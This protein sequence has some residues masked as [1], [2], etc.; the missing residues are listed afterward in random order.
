MRI[1]LTGGTGVLGRATVPKLVAAGH[2][3]H[4]VSRREESDRALRGVGAEPLRLDLFDGDAVIAAAANMEAIV[5]LATHIPP[6]SQAALMKSWEL[7]NRLRRDASRNLAEAAIAAGARFVQESFAPTY[8]ANGA[9]WI[10]EEHPLDPVA[11]TLTVV[12]AENNA[13]LVTQ[14]GGVGV[15]LRFGLFYT[16]DSDQTRQMIAAARKGRL[17]LPGPPERY[18]ALIYVPDAAAAVVAALTIPPGVYNVVEDHPLTLAEHGVILAGLLGRD[19]IKPL[20]AL[21]GRMRVMRALAR[22]QRISN[23]RLR[24][25]SDWRPTAPSGR[26]GWPMVLAEVERG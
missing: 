14:K 4:A 12:D 24:A 23:A 1:L 18:A 5:N 25:A 11:Q 9:E 7:N 6:T 16:A 8:A 21:A 13:D 17:L 10:G 15:T 19:A 26:E 22:S 3:V 2:E 20:P